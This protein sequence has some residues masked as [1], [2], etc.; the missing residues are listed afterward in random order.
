M[1]RRSIHVILPA[2]LA[3]VACVT[4]CG[5]DTP[6]A[7]RYR[8]PNRDQIRPGMSSIDASARKAIQQQG[9]GLVEKGPDTG[10]KSD[11]VLPKLSET[12]FIEGAKHRDPF[13]PFL[14]VIVRQEDVEQ[15][16]QRE[17]KLKD[18]DISDLKL[19]AIVTNIGDERAMV[20]TPTNDGIVLR[21]GDYV[22]KPEYVETGAGEKIQVN[23][24]VARIHGSGKDEERGVYL[25][26]DDPLTETPEDVTRFLP[27]H[28]Q[29]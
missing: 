10:A 3:L 4:A 15:K 11:L 6:S 8:R 5:E 7:P 21:R 2:L 12:D 9:A 19:I 13:R 27:L 23:W 22:G 14:E 20:V 25:V 26:R 1:M 18:Y 16:V 24:R 29:Q 17:V 28:P